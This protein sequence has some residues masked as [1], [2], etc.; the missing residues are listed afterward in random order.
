MAI[1]LKFV[2]HTAI[3]VCSNLR[4][5]IFCDITLEGCLDSYSDSGGIDVISGTAAKMR[6]GGIGI[7]GRGLTRL[8]STKTSDGTDKEARGSLRVT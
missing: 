2:K 5:G 3:T 4:N 7:L 1:L 6:R 8:P